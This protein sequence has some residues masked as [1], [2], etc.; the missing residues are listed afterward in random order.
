M[1]MIVTTTDEIPGRKI[2]EVLG[3]VSGTSIPTRHLG[4]DITAA[5]KNIAGAHLGEYEKLIES[6]KVDSMVK[7]KKEA[8]KLEA[9]AVVC[10]RLG[11]AQLMSGAAEITWYGTAVKLE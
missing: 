11:T 9:D 3:V 6:A 5:F 1:I 10:A 4:R 2:K 8:E 7:M